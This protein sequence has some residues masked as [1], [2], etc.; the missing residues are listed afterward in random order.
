MGIICNV[1]NFVFKVEIPKHE[2]E[3]NEAAI[4]EED[5]TQFEVDMVMF[6][7]DNLSLFFGVPWHQCLRPDSFYLRLLLT[8]KYYYMKDAANIAVEASASLDED[9]CMENEM[10]DKLDI[11]MEI[12]FKYIHEVTHIN[13]K[14]SK[15]N[16][17]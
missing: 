15:I 17:F 8:I 6:N 3:H 9:N 13:G 10:A 5:H 11:L 4:E 1:H 12:L 2:L 16:I 7:I 14:L